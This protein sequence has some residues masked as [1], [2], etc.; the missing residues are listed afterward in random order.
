MKQRLVGLHWWLLASLL[1][2][3]FGQAQASL[4]DFQGEDGYRLWLKYDLVAD[5][6]LRT[7]YYKQVSDIYLEDNSETGQ[8]IKQELSLALPALLGKSV[9]FTNK[10]SQ[11]GLIIKLKQSL[12]ADPT[13][14]G[15][16]L[17]THK[18]KVTLSAQN[19]VGLLYG[20]FHL[21]R[22]M[23]TEQSLAKLDINQAPKIKLRMLN[24][25]D[26]LDRHTERGYAG[27]S[28]FDWHKLPDYKEQRYYDY[29]RANAS[30]G[31]NGIV[32]INVN[33]NALILSSAY[34]QKVQALADIFR[35]Y[36][37][38]VYL[39]IKFSSPQQLDGLPTSDPVDPQVQQWWQ[40]KAA[41]IYK[42][43]PDFG[44]FLV[45][46]NSEGQPGPG[47]YGR[48]HDIGAN[49]LAKALKPYGGN[50]LWRAFVYAHDSEHERSLQAYTEFVPLDGEFADN[51]SVQVKNG[52]IDF[53]PREPFS[54]LFGAMPQT[55]LAMEFQITQEY[56]GF[57]THL[58][59]LG[60]MYKEVL[61]ADTHVQGEGSTVAKVIDGS[62][63]KAPLTVMAGVANIGADR[64]WTGHIFA[65][66]NW[67][68]LGR[69]AWDHDLSAEQ[70]AQE[71][72]AMTLTHDAIASE[73][74][75]AMMMESRE[76]IVDY[77][78]P[79]GLHHLMDT[80]HHYGPGPWVDNLGRSD[81]NPTYYHRADA[82]GIG[83]DRT[84]SGTNAVSQYA[85]YWQ[86]IFSDPKKT[87]DNL[88]L[89]FHHLP[90]DYKMRSG[91]TLWVELVDHYYAGAAAIE[92]MQ[93]QWLDLKDKIEPNQFNQVRM[94]LAIQVK[95]AKWWRDACVLYFQT[96][97][98]M[99]IPEGLEK[100]Q[101]SLEYYQS[102]KFP[103]APGQG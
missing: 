30:I 37:I 85:P 60:T 31:I 18:G 39:A 92:K 87:P 62:L 38:K 8:V 58:A 10:A 29:A 19:P 84:K 40:D 9:R 99:P 100:P 103:Y 4:A 82:N 43:I 69:L 2:V 15:F 68:V 44:G 61:D 25:W 48:T 59:Y 28:I 93:Q 6:T 72:V 36:G 56:L 34:L 89:W 5:K 70:I 45:K 23:Q 20:T 90:W 52:P 95:E 21:L 78:T 79:L 54:P 64:N 51:V 91:N 81:W 49:M 12:Q 41:E 57:S 74:I 3:V 75:V 35:P 17:Q 53:Q 65:Q 97:S 14:E 98:K 27:E 102:L 86:D 50:V 47:D 22:L 11:A 46:A 63:S 77:M 66:A 94:A 26:D 101:H 96:Y 42:L 88:L 16:D 7:Q 71:W 32:P 1:C 83:L 67:Y 55:S 73:Q 13:N 24:H 80:G 76:D 33:S